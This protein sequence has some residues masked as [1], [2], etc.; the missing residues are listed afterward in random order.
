M[1][2]STKK[3]TV[4]SAATVIVAAITGIIVVC[5]K[6]FPLLVAKDSI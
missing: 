6:L 2:E 1:S 5:K 3:V 4:V